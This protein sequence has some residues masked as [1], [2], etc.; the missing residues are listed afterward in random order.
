MVFLLALC[1]NSPP[2]S[3]S[4]TRLKHP[5]AG[6]LHLFQGPVFPSLP[7]FSKLIS[8]LGVLFPGI[9][10]LPWRHF[11]PSPTPLPILCAQARL[12][13]PSLTT[14]CSSNFHQTSQKPH[15][16]IPVLVDSLI[17]WPASVSAAAPKLY[18]SLDTSKSRRGLK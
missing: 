1:T 17:R 11:S 2:E 12:R 8:K 18:R 4:Q 14:I 5:L 3:R 16:V 9:F 15:K 10:I 13:C 6:L 7:L